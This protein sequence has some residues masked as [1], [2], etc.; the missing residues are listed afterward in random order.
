MIE[1]G[2]P[3]KDALLLYQDHRTSDDADQMDKDDCLTTKG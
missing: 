3:L 2:L 1:R